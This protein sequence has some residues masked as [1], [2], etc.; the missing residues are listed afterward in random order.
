MH[1]SRCIVV[2]LLALPL[3]PFAVAQ[4]FPAKPIRIIVGPG[5]DIVARIFGQKFTEAWGQ[6]AVVDTRPGGGGTIAAELVAKAAPDG[7]TLLLASAAYTINAVLQPSSFDLIRDFS[8][9]AF[10]ASAPFILVVNP[11]LPVRS[12]QEIIA[13]AKSK[14]GQINY[15]S[16]GNG[17]P[18]HLAGELFKSMAHI[19]I[20]HVPYK[21]AAPA[22]VDVVGGQVQMMFAITSISL[23]QVQAGKVRGLGVTSAQRSPLA[24]D[25]PTLAESGLPGYEVIGWNG[26]LAP[27]GTPRAVVSKINAEVQRSLQQPDVLQ[28]LKGSAYDPA[29]ANTPEQFAEYIRLEI[30]KWTKLVKETGMKVD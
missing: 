21:N 11:S 5:P 16:S 6:Q 25:L 17:T 1:V 14:P 13:L 26:L 3:M 7:Y 27:A 4:E 19:N 20:V 2:V 30:A 22:L 8:A 15:A 12:V 10:C 9:V 23:G 24:P 29:A 28:R 18:P